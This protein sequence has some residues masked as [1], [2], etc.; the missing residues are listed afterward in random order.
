MHKIADGLLSGRYSRPAASLSAF[1][2][3]DGA[4]GFTLAFSTETK[5]SGELKS[6]SDDVKVLPPDK[7]AHDSPSPVFQQ[8][9]KP[10]GFK[11]LVGKGHA[12]FATMKQQDSE[13]FLTW[14]VDV[15]RRDW[16]R[17]NGPGAVITSGEY[18][19]LLS[20]KSWLSVCG[21]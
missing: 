16:K 18:P 7:L 6:G 3:S 15:M 20:L 4:P 19:T 1:T 5:A 9:I 2:S 11:A 12:E 17:R 13:E 10:N 14:L 8:G 21:R